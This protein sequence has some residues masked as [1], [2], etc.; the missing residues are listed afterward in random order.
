MEL[1]QSAVETL[2]F[3]ARRTLA[4]GL[5]EPPKKAWRKGARR[6]TDLGGVL[7]TIKTFFVGGTAV[8]VGAAVVAVTAATVAASTPPAL[9]HR[10]QAPADKPHVVAPLASQT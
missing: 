2:I 9:R 10:L 5:Q 4:Q 6:G 1:S 7:A 3:R 8:K